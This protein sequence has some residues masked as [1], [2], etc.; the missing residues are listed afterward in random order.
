MS[1]A[2]DELIEANAE[3]FDELR[4]E[5][6]TIDGAEP[7]VYLLQKNEETGTYTELLQLTASHF[8]KFEEIRGQVALKV[9][10]IDSTFVT[11][12]NA[13][14]DFAIGGQ[15]Y[16]CDRRDKESPQGSQFYYLMYGVQDANTYDGT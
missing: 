7:E 3:A 15:V 2:A 9:A 5:L 1:T 6:L 10:R 11:A 14:S 12:Y 8:W 4:A 16:T 13:M